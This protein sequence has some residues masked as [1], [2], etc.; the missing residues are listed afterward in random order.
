MQRAEQGATHNH[1]DEHNDDNHTN[2]HASDTHGNAILP[3]LSD[4]RRRA[5]LADTSNEN[6]V[7]GARVA[8]VHAVRRVVV[9]A[10]WTRDA[11]EV[12]RLGR[13]DKGGTSGTRVGRESTSRRGE[14]CRHGSVVAKHDGVQVARDKGGHVVERQWGGQNATRAPGEFGLLNVTQSVR[15]VLRPLWRSRVEAGLDGDIQR[16]YQ[17]PRLIV[18]YTPPGGRR[19]CGADRWQHSVYVCQQVVRTGR[20]QHLLHVRQQLRVRVTLPNEMEL[21]QARLRRE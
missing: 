1:Y 4:G 18:R 21:L 17:R 14:R 11:G 5:E 9:H 19:E 20:V 12:S 3:V 15:S 7:A 13:T 2:V 10:G 8:L 6:S 16:V